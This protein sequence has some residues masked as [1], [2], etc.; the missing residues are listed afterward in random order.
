M[1]SFPATGVT[2]GAAAGT[3]VSAAA[4]TATTI[5]TAAAAGAAVEIVGNRIEDAGMGIEIS[6]TG[7]AL[8]ASP[9]SAVTAVAADW[10]PSG[11]ASAGA[12]W[13][14]ATGCKPV[15]VGAESWV[16]ATVGVSTATVTA[17]GPA[18]VL[19][20]VDDA[21][22]VEASDALAASDCD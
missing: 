7:A 16:E 1:L 21:T 13:L 8:V 5:G 2:A 20:A 22:E 3:V 12:I 15:S 10:T 14:V 19:V 17:T 6:M 11:T 9:A 4:A 18:P